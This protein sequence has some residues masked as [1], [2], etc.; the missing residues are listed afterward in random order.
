V[1]FLWEEKTLSEAGDVDAM[2]CFSKL[3]AI[4]AD[5]LALRLV[6]TSYTNM[7]TELSMGVLWPP[8][9]YKH[10]VGRSPPRSEM[11][12]IRHN[13][14]IYVG[15]IRDTKFGCPTGSQEGNNITAVALGLGVSE[16]AS[17]D[18]SCALLDFVLRF[19]F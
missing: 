13:G 4:L 10:D 16:P 11:R 9:V 15:I 19:R 8:A 6:M 3:G 5:V 17:S 12:R 18:V 1:V 2:S 7:E 14:E